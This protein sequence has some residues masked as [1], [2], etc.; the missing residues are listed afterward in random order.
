MIH[1]RGRL[2]GEGPQVS[3]EGGVVATTKVLD[4]DSYR[5]CDFVEN[6]DGIECS[7]QSKVYFKLPQVTPTNHIISE[8]KC[9]TNLREMFTMYEIGSQIILYVDDPFDLGDD[10][11]S[12]KEGGAEEPEGEGKEE[13]DMGDDS[14]SEREG[15]AEEPED[16]GE[17]EPD[18][19]VKVMTLLIHVK[20][21]LVVEE[22]QVFYEGGE[23]ATSIVLDIDRYH[24]DDLV[25]H[26]VGY[27]VPNKVKCISSF[28]KPPQL[29]TLSVS[30]NVRQMLGK[31]LQCMRLVV[32]SMFY[33]D[34]SFDFGD[35]SE[36]EREGG[37]E[38]P[39]DEGEEEPDDG[40]KK[41]P[42]DGGAEET[43][44]EGEVDSDVSDPDYS[45]SGSETD[46]TSG[47][48]D[49]SDDEMDEDGYQPRND[50]DGSQP[51]NDEGRN[52]PR[53]KGLITSF[54]RLV[55]NVEH[56]YCMRH[57]YDNFQ[58]TCK[59]KEY[60][61]LMWELLQHIPTRQQLHLLAHKGPPIKVQV[62]LNWDIKCSFDEST[63]FCYKM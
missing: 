30:Y 31:C 13:P 33:V 50:E 24:Y 42:H 3:Y 25:K 63:H 1:V 5:Y 43:D 54:D 62:T 15:G 61:D 10:S 6:L 29:M 39:E 22:P 44:G 34:V 11:E 41:N 40:G 26:W 12:E 48:D 35:D 56:R 16:E 58:K 49:S 8:L 9:E 59:G 19:G 53:Q 55:P 51:R 60:K 4:I 14:E 18:M 57:L 32:K 38:E 45:G 20:G 23:V 7:R 46:K 28:H 47:L 36:S 37:A 52:E 21:R 17:E 2:V 27:N